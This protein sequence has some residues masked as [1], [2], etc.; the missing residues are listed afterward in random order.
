MIQ[1]SKYLEISTFYV[2]VGREKEFL[3]LW[4]D[5]IC[6]LTEKMGGHNVSIYFRQE[7]ND[8]LFTSHWPSLDVYL[9]YFNSP[10]LKEWIEKINDICMKPTTYE[11]YKIIEERVA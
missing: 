7:T 10:A 4:Q 8:Y 9:K 2:E 5:G 11:S 6:K 1:K 3:S